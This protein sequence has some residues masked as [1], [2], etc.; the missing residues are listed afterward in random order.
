LRFG[1]GF[2]ATL[3]VAVAVVLLAGPTQTTVSW[4]SPPSPTLGVLG[5]TAIAAGA[6]TRTV[7]VVPA[8][9]GTSSQCVV[10]TVANPYP[11]AKAGYLSFNGNLFALPVASVGSS[12]LC[13][14]A[15]NGALY[16]HTDFSALPG[17]IAHDV[18]GYPEAILGENLYGG[19][20]GRSST[21]LPLPNE[22]ERSL[23]DTN[24]WITMH[25]SVTA[26]GGSPYDFAFDDWLTVLPAN[27]SST[28]NEGNRIEIMI[29]L[30]ND[31]GMYLPQTKVDIPSFVN[32]S[33]APGTWYRDQL[34]M[35]TNDITFDFLYAPDGAT[36]GFGLNHATVSV[37]LTAILRSV[38]SVLRSGACWAPTGTGIGSMYA[39]AFPLGAEFYPTL[40]LTSQ[41]SW[42]VASLCYVLMP[43]APRSGGPSC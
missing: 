20:G 32:G 26:T 15:A 31:I 33:T 16:D 7:Q 38:A 5:T 17:A 41:F 24:V 39:S 40:S 25:Y 9:A 42:H 8:P 12:Q 28:G 2:A 34:C 13:Y 11:Q 43:G 30:S 21:I 27:G 3:V 35:G 10:A 22:R 37:N 36:P 29:W 4:P 18:L 14:N 23:T 19:L 6:T 1:G